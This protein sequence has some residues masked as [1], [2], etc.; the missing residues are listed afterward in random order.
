MGPLDVTACRNSLRTLY[1]SQH[2][3]LFK[4]PVDPVR[5]NAPNYLAVISEPMDLSTIENK[6]SSG[7]YSDR[8]AFKKDFDLMI[9][10]AKAYTP[11]PRAFVHIEADKLG[12]EFDR[13][14]SRIS[15]TIEAAEAKHK[16]QAAKAAQDEDDDVE[17]DE[18]EDEPLLQSTRPAPSAPSRSDQ[19]EEDDDAPLAITAAPPPA[20]KAKPVKLKFKPRASAPAAPAPASTGSPPPAAASRSTSAVPAPAAPVPKVRMKLTKPRSS[21]P[22]ATPAPAVSPPAPAAPVRPSSP[23][24]PH[25]GVSAKIPKVPAK[26]PARAHAP[27]PAKIP[28]KPPAKTTAKAPVKVQPKL[29]TKIPAKSPPAAAPPVAAPRPVLPHKAS[30]SAS[31]PASASV[32]SPPVA[33]SAVAKPKVKA[34][35]AGADPQ[36]DLALSDPVGA[37]GKA[38]LHPKRARA[39]IQAL[40][41]LPEAIFFLRPVDPI[42]D[43]APTYLEEIAHPMDLG[44]ME[45]KV[46]A[47]SYGRMSEFAS[48]ALL[49]FAN[50]RQFN[51]PA[52]VPYIYADAVEAAFLQEWSKA[53]VPSLEY[54]EKRALQGLLSRLKHNV[55]VSGLFLQ[56]VDPVALGIPHYF[57]VIP[58]EDAR[59]LSLI[60]GKLKSDQYVSVKGF[61]DDVA[62]MVGNA[63]K[64]NALDPAVLALVDAFDKQYRKELATARQSI[65]HALGIAEAPGAKRKS[66]GVTGASA[67]VQGASKKP[68]H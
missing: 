29:A 7:L 51:P 9:A 41:K 65:N 40:K 17:E 50:A 6:L 68:R 12:R 61:T 47:G 66:A 67:S 35:P 26:A 28:A 44:T 36:P 10:N 43:G 16:A 1:S 25:A 42:L 52:T 53:L 30:T 27:V 62:L 48:D 8:T 15:R 59:D 56:P 18:D 39:V 11:D 32:A 14:W 20:P 64:F 37:A 23:P 13:H 3:W 19:E 24:A 49:I 2:A 31:P 54:A 55:L 45:K 58:K 34:S 4:N 63:R 5:D 38:P 22:A 57:S 21:M 46:N 33:G 60:E